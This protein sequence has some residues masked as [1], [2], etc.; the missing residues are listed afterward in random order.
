MEVI[1]R[2]I[3]RT[4]QTGNNFRV[5]FNPYNRGRSQLL[6]NVNKATSLLPCTS[7]E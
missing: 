5:T 4:Q 2:R 6:F 1:I 7:E 3:F